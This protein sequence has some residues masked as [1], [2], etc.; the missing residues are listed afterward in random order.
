MT[1][2]RCRELIDLLSGAGTIEEIHALCCVLCKESGFD[3]FIYGT[4]I[5]TSFV[6]PHI[7][8][9]SSY[10]QAWRERYVVQ[11]YLRI[12]PTVTHCANH[13]LPLTWDRIGPL[14]EEDEA[15]RNFMAESRDFGLKNGVSFP[16][17]TPQGEFAMLSMAL[18]EGKERSHSLI[19]HAIPYVQ[20]ISLHIHEAVRRAVNIVNA[21]FGFPRL[22]EREKECLLWIAEGKTSWETSMIIGIS[23]RT[24]IFHLQNVTEKL[25]VTNRQQ[26]VAR[27][28]SVGLIAPQL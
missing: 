2:L 24:V 27:A 15:V 11:G 14:E 4:R 19:L 25:K 22:S 1:P 26:A 16:I 3:Y 7:F 6:K 13:F 18:G 20:L 8:I 12:D 5:P 23:E 21:P 17:H 10:P 28:V 9:I